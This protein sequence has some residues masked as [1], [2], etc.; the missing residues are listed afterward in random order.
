MCQRHIRYHRTAS[1]IAQLMASWRTAPS[2]C[3]KQYWIIIKVFRVFM[4]EHFRRMCLYIQSGL[5]SATIFFKLF[6][7]LQG[8]CDGPNCDL[9]WFVVM[10]QMHP[11]WSKVYWFVIRLVIWVWTLNREVFCISINDQTIQNHAC[12]YFIH[13]YMIMMQYEYIQ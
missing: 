10:Y 3:L 7:Y 1:T 4:S 12:Q 2:H 13:I 11:L 6:P 5:D 8:P 9:L